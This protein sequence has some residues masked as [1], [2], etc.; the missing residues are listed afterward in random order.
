MKT[1]RYLKPHNGK[2]RRHRRP[3]ANK[4]RAAKAPRSNSDRAEMIRQA[5]VAEKIEQRKKAK[6]MKA[7]GP[8]CASQKAVQ[9]TNQKLLAELQSTVCNRVWNNELGCWQGIIPRRFI[10]KNLRHMP[11]FVE[12]AG[13]NGY[14]R[15]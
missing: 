9:E 14:R 8:C 1:N 13:E 6:A 12:F 11:H 4:N 10:Q 3:L 2:S 15:S 7:D 5:W